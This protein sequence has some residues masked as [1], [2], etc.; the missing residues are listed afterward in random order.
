MPDR[1]VMGAIYIRT[2]V[3]ACAPELIGAFRR[4][5]FESRAARAAAAVW[6]RM[7]GCPIGRLK[8]GKR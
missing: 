5:R 1:V 2:D 4:A 6:S 7:P 8:R 3:A